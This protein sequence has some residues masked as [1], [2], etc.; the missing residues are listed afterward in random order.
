M[1]C[2]VCSTRWP[3]SPSESLFYLRWQLGHKTRWQTVK[4]S[5]LVASAI[6]MKREKFVCVLGGGESVL[7]SKF[8]TF[9]CLGDVAFYNFCPFSWHPWKRNGTFRLRIHCVLPPCGGSFRRLQLYFCQD[10]TLGVI[11]TLFCREA[12][13]MSIYNNSNF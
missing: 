3:Y 13:Q 12:V 5:S 1:V 11:K 10:L 6:A 8:H 2:F 9:V 7:D 4:T